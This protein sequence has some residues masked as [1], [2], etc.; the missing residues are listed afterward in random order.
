LIEVWKRDQV[1]SGTNQ[2][3]AIGLGPE[4]GVDADASEGLFRPPVAIRII[5]KVAS[6]ESGTTSAGPLRRRCV[7]DTGLGRV[8]ALRCISLIA[9]VIAV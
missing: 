2:G 5:P 8:V 4:S 1:L 6:A 9:A 3:T 7:D